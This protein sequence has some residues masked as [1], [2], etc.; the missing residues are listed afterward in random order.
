MEWR[1]EFDA[2]LVGRRTIEADDPRLTRRLGLNR[3]TPQ[4]RIVLDGRFRVP[5]DAQLFSTGEGVEVWTASAG[6]REK[7]RRLARRGVRIVRFPPAPA[8]RVDLRRALRKLGREGVS[9]LLVEGGAATIAS[10]H[11]R[12]LVDRWAIFFAPRLL[13]GA[14]SLPFLGGADRPLGSSLPLGALE[15]EMV[16]DDLLVTGVP[17]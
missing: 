5:E 4:R 14:H 2:V 9:G 11:E 6:G 7:E 3:A 10:F 12:G 8:A 17:R 15:H 13:G 16:G 1:E